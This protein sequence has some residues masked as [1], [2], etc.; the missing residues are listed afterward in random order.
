MAGSNPQT[1]AAATGQSIGSEDP[2][3]G[4]SSPELFAQA[5]S[6]ARHPRASALSSHK[7]H[8]LNACLNACRGAVGVQS[9]LGTRAHHLFRSRNDS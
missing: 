2:E 7:P 4:E 1:V 8:S 9:D 6:Q 3:L 5:S